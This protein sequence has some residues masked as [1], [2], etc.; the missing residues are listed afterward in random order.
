MFPGLAGDLAPVPYRL[1]LGTSPQFLT[2][3]RL[4]RSLTAVFP[5]FLSRKRVK[6]QAYEYME[7]DL[8]SVDAEILLRYPHVH[9][10]RRQVLEESIEKM[11]QLLDSG[12]APIEAEEPV[13]MFLSSV[14]IKTRERFLHELE[15]LSTAKRSCAIPGRRELDPTAVLHNC[16]I[17][18]MMRVAEEDAVPLKDVEARCKQFLPAPRVREQAASLTRELIGHEST[19]EGL[20]KKDQKLLTRLIP[21]DYTKIGCVEKMRPFDV[22]SYFRFYG[23][24]AIKAQGA[25]PFSRYLWGNVFRNYATHPTYLCAMSMHWGRCTDTHPDTHSFE[26]DRVRLP[27]EL[28]EANAT[29]MALFP[30]IKFHTQNS[31]AS[32]EKV[33]EWRTETVA[34]L[35]RL[36]PLIGQLAAEDLLASLAVDRFWR[37]LKL[38]FRVNLHEST[39]TRVVQNFVAETATMRE[40][41][42]DGFLNLLEADV[43]QHFPMVNKD[44]NKESNV[45]SPVGVR[46]VAE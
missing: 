44:V 14:A 31:F 7:I 12:K 39:F 24:R 6:E 26:G 2:E 33:R 40:T 28:A 22:V 37:S 43:S 42:L 5:W 27:F 45:E 9:Y 8:A 35:P 20:D 11:M 10:V 18:A 4:T 30:A 46:A 15:A 1:L 19:R 3:Q 41:N 38:D 25:L 34:P 13:R 17:M 21:P 32:L 23:E 29:Q 16:D 36:F